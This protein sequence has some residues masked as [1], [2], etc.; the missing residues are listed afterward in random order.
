[1]AIVFSVGM[2]WFYY[3]SLEYKKLK[4]D[5]LEKTYEIQRL[6]LTLELNEVVLSTARAELCAIQRRGGFAMHRR[7]VGV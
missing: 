1:M 2:Y 5:N 7:S 3:R 4:K 6:T